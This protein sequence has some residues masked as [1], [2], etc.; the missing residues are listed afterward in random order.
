MNTEILLFL[1]TAQR[2]CRGLLDFSLVT[3]INLN[4]THTNYFAAIWTH[5]AGGAVTR[6]T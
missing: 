4:A 1:P 6:Q 3:P 5:Y 2:A